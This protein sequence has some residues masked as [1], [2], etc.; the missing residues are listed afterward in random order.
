M[1]NSAEFKKCLNIFIL[2]MATWSPALIFADTANWTAVGSDDLQ[3]PAN[4]STNTVPG[5]TDNAS[6][7]STLLNINTNPTS[8]G[9]P[10]EIFN[11]QFINTAFP[12]TF[13]IN[14]TSLILHGQGIV[15]PQTDTKIIAINSDNTS[16]LSSQVSFDGASATSGSAK[17]EIYNNATVTGPSPLNTSSVNTQFESQNDFTIGDNGSLLV[18]NTGTSQTSGG[19]I[20]VSYVQLGQS[21]FNGALIAG[22]NVN[23]NV[24]TNGTC[25]NTAGQTS[26]AN[27][28]NNQLYVNGNF[29]AGDYLQ[30]NVENKGTDSSSGS[31]ANNVAF[32]NISTGSG[33]QLEFNQT[34]TVGNNAFF[35]VVNSGSFSG[36]HTVNNSTVASV[37]GDQAYFNDNFTAG[38]LLVVKV[39]NSGTDDGQ[40]AGADQVGRVNTSQVEFNAECTVG[41]SASFNV[42]NNGEY[43]GSYTSLGISVGTVGSDQLCICDAF[44]SGNTLDILVSNQGIHSGSGTGIDD[45]GRVLN[46]SQA[47][48]NTF[49]TGDNALISIFNSGTFTGNHTVPSNGNNIGSVDLRQI[50]FDGLF[51]TGNNLLM[52][53]TNNGEADT[54]SANNSV[55]FVGDSQLLFLGGANI[56]DDADINISNTGINDGGTSNRVGYVDGAQFMCNDAFIAGKKF[57]LTANNSG[58][59]FGDNTNLVGVVTDNQI[60]FNAAAT[61]DNGTQIAAFNTGSVTA[62]QIYFSEGFNITSGKISL[63]ADN[64]GSVG[65]HGIFIQGSNAGGNAD[66]ILH[67][68]SLHIDTTLPSFTIA[69]L[70]GDSTSYARSRANLIIN[71]D[72]G[73]NTDFAGVIENFPA[74]SST[75][76]KN[77]K[78]TQRL[79]GNNTYTGLTTVNEGSLILT[80][81]IAGDAL[82]NS[83]GTLKGTGSISGNVT[84]YGTISP[85]ESIGTITFAGTYAN[86][87]GTYEVEVSGTG[88]S[89]LIDVGGTATLNG[90]LVVVSS[91]DGSYSFQQPYTILTSAG[92]TGAFA[93]ATSTAFIHP[94]LTYDANNAYLTIYS[95]LLRAARTN[96]QRSVARRL[97]GIIDPNAEQSLVLSTLVGLSLEDVQDALTSLSGVQFTNNAWLTELA[98]RRF[99]RRIYEPLRPIITKD[100]C[101]CDCDCDSC[102]DLNLWVSTGAGFSKLDRNHN[103]YGYSTSSYEITGGIQKTIWEYTTVGATGSFEYEHITYGSHSG[104]GNR[105]TGF[106]ALYGLY[107]PVGYYGYA[108]VAYG[109]SINNF[110]RKID[111]VDLN[112]GAHSR[113]RTNSITFYGEFGADFNLSCWLI[114]PFAALQLGRNRVD[115][116]NENHAGGMGLS[117]HKREWNSASTRVGA[118]TTAANFCNGVDVSLDLAW[119]KY[120]SKRKNQVRVQFNEFGSPFCVH[121]INFQQNS[122]DYALTLSSCLCNNIRSYVE[123][124]GESWGKANT[125]NALGGLELNW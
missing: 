95:D 3:N 1:L 63:L 23:I 22:D 125:F 6:F 17:I 56:G 21:L 20:T 46:G 19:N 61:F 48:F 85:G 94:L 101:A 73:V 51:T 121:G 2:A 27:V 90:G 124:G 72:F 93:G 115:H 59:N 96:N 9:T 7:D 68:S 75:L 32:L 86:N 40:G 53:I 111:L 67:N 12:F 4:W 55:G 15:G 82:I 54:A 25:E 8:T 10:F 92:L 24:S 65:L 45:V 57:S 89:D 58:T 74:T 30:V 103:S 112:L 109:N 122:V 113:P 110:C 81:S 97:D 41:N 14:N 119:N 42:S 80:G 102:N 120:F 100:P 39:E 71:T 66:V 38:D 123:I 5:P 47:A 49:T 114:Q 118:H 106:V 83:S 64:L 117:V 79:S 76:T 44:Q 108:D 50:A 70:T 78:G 84:N 43:S 69:S 33:R 52:T 35:S 29:Q 91:V 60:A 88:Q 116:T 87:G 28:L 105:N 98:N 36:N 107:R 99:Q 18:E 31:D 16:I 104:N 26:V 34:T 11:L 77:G 13:H 37:A 62:S